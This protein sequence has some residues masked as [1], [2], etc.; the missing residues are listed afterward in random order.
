VTNSVDAI[1]RLS[2]VALLSDGSTVPIVALFDC[3]GEET[4][5]PDEAV[6]FTAGEPGRWFSGLCADYEEVTVQ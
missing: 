6:A 1:K 5:D 3:D 2:R 4:D